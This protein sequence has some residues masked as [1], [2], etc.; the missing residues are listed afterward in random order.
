MTSSKQNNSEFDIERKIFTGD[1]AMVGFIDG[2][3]TVITPS[4]YS[5]KDRNLQT[6]KFY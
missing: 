1:W 3:R 2:N 5:F 6:G 4:N